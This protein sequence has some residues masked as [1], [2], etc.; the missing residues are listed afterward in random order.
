MDHNK[1]ADRPP[2]RRE[3]RTRLSDPSPCQHRHLRTNTLSGIVINYCSVYRR[4]RPS[5][6]MVCPARRRSLIRQERQRELTLSR[7]ILS[8]GTHLAG[9][10]PLGRDAN[11]IERQRRKSMSRRVI[12]SGS[13]DA[14]GRQLVSVSRSISDGTGGNTQLSRWQIPSALM[15]S[16]G[17]STNHLPSSYDVCYL[18]GRSWSKPYMSENREQKRVNH[19]VTLFKGQ[20]RVF[21][22]VTAGCRGLGGWN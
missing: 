20:G 13:D 14:N 9:R 7:S 1:S 6:A 5:S 8:S 17:D 2:V 15:A 4:G 19:R 22:G 3:T 11:T 10:V 16:T 21:W 18:R 12:W